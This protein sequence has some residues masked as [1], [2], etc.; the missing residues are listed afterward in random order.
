EWLTDKL[1]ADARDII[2]R[3]DGMGGMLEA[4]ESGY[5]QREIARSAYEL[6]RKIN[7]GERVVVGIN[8]FQTDGEG[9]KIPTLRIDEAVQR[10]QVEALTQVKQGR[11][12]AAVKD[13]L[14]GVRR[15]AETNENLVPKVIEAAKAYATEQEVCDVLR[16][17]FGT[18]T[19][20]AEF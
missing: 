9:D 7:A 2:Q 8:R 6:E 16:S 14:D 3:I 10:A 20:P 15:A 5:P 12:G 11:S 13:A 18:Y 4:V 1:E 17:V 19:D